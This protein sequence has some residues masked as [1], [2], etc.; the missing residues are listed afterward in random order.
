M[1]FA[2]SRINANLGK[3]EK[4]GIFLTESI[5]KILSVAHISKLQAM[6]FRLSP[7]TLIYLDFKYGKLIF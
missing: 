5:D 4:K 3:F 1:F 2:V 7:K 6:F